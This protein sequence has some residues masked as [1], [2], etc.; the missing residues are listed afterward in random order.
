[1]NRTISILVCVAAAAV[2]A[3]PAAGD[4]LAGQILKFQQLP[5][6]GTEISVAGTAQKYWGH[7]ELSTAWSRY[8]VNP[9]TGATEFIGYKGAFMADDF[10]DRFRMPV[11]HV[12]WWGS[13]INN[14]IIQPV[15]KFLIAFE[16][17][18]PKGPFSGD[19]SQPGEVLL[20]QVVKKGKLSPGSGTYTENR[21][22][23]TSAA[24][25]T[26]D[27]YEYNAE[28][29][30]P[31]N[32][33]PCDIYWLKIVALV[34]V[35][36]D[37]VPGT[38]AV[39]EWGWHNRDWTKEDPLACTINDKVDPGEHVQGL[40][41]GDTTLPIWH[42]QD[43]AVRGQIVIAAPVDPVDTAVDQLR[44]TF[45]AQYYKDILDG[46]DGISQYSKDLAF[47]LYTIPEPATMLLLALGGATAL[48]RRRR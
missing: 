31:F 45:A 12:R 20:S 48:V 39:T 43:D 19:F 24:G 16:S 32:Q 47:E 29:A 44:D 23:V 36:E 26:E 15:D 5:M 7:D 8:T 41:N 4:P 34:D 27:L 9:K 30:L 22:T 40:L 46:P 25:A 33:H 17:D 37:I 35:D 13:Y 6:N 18:V 11:V 28:L 21:I 38:D 1:V 3:A 2:W 42:F 10:A 14:E